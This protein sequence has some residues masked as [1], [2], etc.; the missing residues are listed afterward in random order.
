[1]Q[2]DYCG[3]IPL[4]RVKSLYIQAM[5]QSKR[6]KGLTGGLPRQNTKYTERQKEVMR[7]LC[8][9]LTQK[10]IADKIG[11]KPSAVKSHLILIYRKLD[12]STGIDAIMRINELRV[13]E[14]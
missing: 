13:L 11:I 6:H 12:V 14:D 9:G 2:K 3:G 5:M 1:M 4:A 7:H 8:D 10:E